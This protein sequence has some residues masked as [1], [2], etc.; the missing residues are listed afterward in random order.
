[1]PAPYV[2][3]S[4]KSEEV[5]YAQDLIQALEALGVGS[6]A[7]FKDVQTSHAT[8]I[9]RAIQGASAVVILMSS[10]SYE[11][12]EVLDE[13]YL[14]R[15]LKRLRLHVLL[16]G[17][18]DPFQME[19]LSDDIKDAWEMEL[20][21]RQ[22]QPWGSA[23]TVAAWVASAITREAPT[24]TTLA[25]PSGVTPPAS[26]SDPRRE[27]LALVSS[28]G[29]TYQ[30]EAIQ[31]FH[32]NRLY[33]GEQISTGDLGLVVLAPDGSVIATLNEHHDVAIWT[34]GSSTSLPGPALEAVLPSGPGAV[35]LLAI[36]RPIGRAIRIVAA[37]GGSA[38]SVIEQRDGT[39][40]SE[41]LATG[42]EEF[43]GGAAVVDDLLLVREGG[44]I[45]WAGDHAKRPFGLRT[46]R[47][48]DS[49]F[50]PDGRQYLAG[51]GTGADGSSQV[52]AVVESEG[53]WERVHRGPGSRAGIIR[54]LRDA[55]RQSPEPATVAIAVQSASDG[56][57]LVS[58]GI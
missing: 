26:S 54:V 40:A 57:D 8:E 29:M 31:G 44:D 9:K 15:K 51:W 11:S 41:Q 45:V 6:W 13:V 4:Y 48:V 38:Y 53:G 20:G 46:V 3:I 28:L 16:P 10:R 34:L 17:E 56:V 50:G 27:P 7:A 47:G 2:F 25:G 42:G 22:H 37:R 5:A 58:I 1:M 49:A 30:L 35:R 36:E 43:V 19:G 18:V 33:D 39:W 14:A 32:E 24:T 55:A 12:D 21:R 23:E 52:E